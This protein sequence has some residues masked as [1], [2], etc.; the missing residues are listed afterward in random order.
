MSAEVIL[1]VLAAFAAVTLPVRRYVFSDFPAGERSFCSVFFAFLLMALVSLALVRIG[2]YSV[3]AISAISVLISGLFSWAVTVMRTG[4]NCPAPS[5]PFSASV[6]IVLGLAL[7]SMLALYSAYP[8][9]YMLGGRDPGLYLLFSQYIARTGGLNLHLPVLGSTLAQYSHVIESSYPAIY[10]AAQRGLSQDSTQLVPQFQHLFPAVGA[11]FYSAAGIE[12]LVRANAFIAV[13]ALWGYFVTARRVVGQWPALVSMVAL[14]IDPAVIWEARITLTEA[15]SLAILFGGMAF[16][17]LSI[18]RRNRLLGAVAGI[19][20]GCSLLNRLDGGFAGLVVL[21]ITLYATVFKPRLRSVT[22]AM[23]IAYGIASTIG[24]IDGYYNSHPYFHDLWI[25]GSLQAAIGLNYG[26]ILLCGIMLLLPGKSKFV[27]W[28]AQYGVSWGAKSG[29]FVLA[30]WLTFSYFI[31]PNVGQGLDAHASVELAWYV[32]PIVYPLFL[33]GAFLVARRVQWEYCLP[34]LLVAGA[35]VFVFTFRPGISPD[36]I[37]ATRRW[38]PYTIP[39]LTILATF[40][41]IAAWHQLSLRQ[42]RLGLLVGC[43]VI[44][45]YYGWHSYE[46][47]KPFLFKSMLAGLPKQYEILAQNL[48]TKLSAAPAQS[49]KWVASNDIQIASFLTYFYDIPTVLLNGSAP[50]ARQLLNDRLF[51]GSIPPFGESKLLHRDNIC[52]PYLMHRVSALPRKLYQRCFGASI[53]IIKPGADESFSRTA[54]VLNGAFHT[55]VGVADRE[56]HTLSSVGR[57]GFLL[58]GPYISLGPGKYTVRWNGH[59]SMLPPSTKQGYVDVSTSNGRHIV[60]RKKLK[61]TPDDGGSSALAEITFMLTAPVHQ[62][63]FRMYVRSGVKLVLKSVSL[64]KQNTGDGV[65]LLT[66]GVQK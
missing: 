18:D 32:S 1:T 37:W 44:V 42:A 5:A 34:L 62:V 25:G 41:L 49:N 30:V 26:E 9:Y 10:N 61:L 40:C 58:F 53:G 8:T 4:A 39:M 17:W 12:G 46:V 38:V 59:V 20:L 3:P 64:H 11:I 65:G 48:R 31:L 43:S 23:V 52:G 22:V 28:L 29:V 45:G 33:I 54:S 21:G 50:N 15:L 57:A 36:L 60:M 7:L 55:Q 56:A 16:A 35:S 19:A 14:G 2:W 51:V 6:K 63:E 13:L 24:F 27:R 47:S 66:S